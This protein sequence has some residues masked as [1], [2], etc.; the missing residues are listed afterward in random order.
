MQ[1]KGKKIPQNPRGN[2]KIKDEITVG[3][4]LTVQHTEMPK[5]P[6]KGTAVHKF[7]YL[8]LFKEEKCLGLKYSKSA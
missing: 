3:S 4:H 7:K 2:E 6:G 8:L 5:I 1:G